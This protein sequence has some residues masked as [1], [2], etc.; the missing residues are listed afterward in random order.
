MHTKQFTTTTKPIILFDG[1]C[2]LCDRS[3]NFVLKRDSKEYFLFCALQT[4]KATKILSDLNHKLK[5]MKSIVLIENNKTY[6][7]STAAL[8]IVKKLNYGWPLLY[9]FII[10]PPFIRNAV[11]D[12]VAKRRYTWYGKKDTCRI[13]TENEISRFIC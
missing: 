11:Y 3:V 2:N 9:A 5:D 1:Y 8:R 6:T 7:K 13:P 10:I 4:N 12:F